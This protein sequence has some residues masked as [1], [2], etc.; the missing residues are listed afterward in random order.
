MPEHLIRY[1]TLYN[2]QC[3]TP[4]LY[5]PTSKHSLS[6][7]TI[8]TILLGTVYVTDTV[9]YC[10]CCKLLLHSIMCDKL[11]VGYCMCDKLVSIQFL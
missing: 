2:T 6:C 9:G 1:G 4:I 8:Q 11:S 10:M 5:A 7:V 3:D